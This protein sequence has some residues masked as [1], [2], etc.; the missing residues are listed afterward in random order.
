MKKIDISKLWGANY[1]LAMC[2]I[3]DVAP[4]VADLGLEVKELFVLEQIDDYPNP[5]SLAEVL[6]MPKPTVTVYLKRLEAGGFVK[7]EIDSK[8]LRRHHMTLTPAGRKVMAKGSA[9]I[10]D[11]L[12]KRLTKLT[13]TQQVQLGDLLETL[14][15]D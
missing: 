5:A 4:S 2:V 6:V 8:D 11:A 14:T 3:A 15:S 10:V 1:R 13:P 7:R 12:A 9:L